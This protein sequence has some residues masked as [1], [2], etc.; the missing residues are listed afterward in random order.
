MDTFFC[1]NT[2]R[3]YS[4]IN[5]LQIFSSPEFLTASFCG[6]WHAL[7]SIWT[8]SELHIA[9]NPLLHHGIALYNPKCVHLCADVCGVKC[10]SVCAVHIF[11][12]LQKCSSLAGCMHAAWPQTV[13]LLSAKAKAK[14]KAKA[15]I[16]DGGEA[17]H[18]PLLY[19]N[20][21]KNSSFT[22]AR[23]TKGSHPHLW[24]L[25]L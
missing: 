25:C 10:V 16:R 5:I 2:R 17:Y 13:V 20:W 15:R 23:F 14:A 9:L 19:L 11:H 24:E 6:F 7:A 3:D 8:Q 18:G 1:S 4:C 21:Q 12:R 22:Q